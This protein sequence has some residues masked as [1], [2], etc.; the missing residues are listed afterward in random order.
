MSRKVTFVELH[1][2]FFIPGVLAD[3]GGGQFGKQLPPASKTLVDLDMTL[4]DSGALEMEWGPGHNRTA[5]TIGA[6]NIKYAKHA[7]RE[8]KPE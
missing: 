7:P 2:G 5:I 3:Q 1:E 6:A 4:L 8:K